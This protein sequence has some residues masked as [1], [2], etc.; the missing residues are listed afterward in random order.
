MIRAWVQVVILNAFFLPSVFAE[1][2]NLD[3]AIERALNTDPR[4]SE[5]E[6]LVDVARATLAE[7]QGS[8]DL[9]ISVNSFIGLSPGLTGGLSVN[10]V[11]CESGKGCVNRTD[12]YTLE[13]GLSLWNYI[14]YRIIKPLY[15][16]GKI[17]HF[18]AAARANIGIKEGDVSVRQGA[19]VLQVKQA[20]YGHLAAADTYAFL[21]DM[22]SRVD[23]S[24]EAVEIW[25]EDG[26]GHVKNADL[27]ALQTAS[28]IAA[29]YISQA[30][31]LKKISLDGLKVLIGVDLEG[32]L[33]LAD[34][35]IRPVP[36]PEKTLEQLKQ[37][38][39][40]VRPEMRQL[41]FGLKARRSLVAANKALS[42][43]NIYTG[44]GGMISYSPNRDRL[45][46]PHIYDPFNDWGGTPVLGMQWEWQG[47]VSSAK[48]A[49][50]KAELAALIEK[51]SFARSGIPFQ[52]SES[53]HNVHAFHD[54]V[55][56]LA[57]SSR[58][59][60]RWMISTYTDFDAGLEQAEKIVTAFQGYVLAHSGYLQT[61]YEYNMHVA[62]LDNVTGVDR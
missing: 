52:V 54:A 30:E 32:E 19:T 44:F 24:I 11:D 3:Q 12:R 42:K 46:N 17:K 55:K 60:R 41:E 39:L 56:N 16:F 29:S 20:Y 31:A 9:K 26:E 13:E 27:F 10:D 4:I 8:D 38:A 37:Q 58:A 21:L 18:S 40:L 5:L 61:V 22:K 7:A 43:P 34:T 23:A 48:V 14:D 49:K 59:A 51:S 36:L 28:G 35:R 50:S 57:K 6:K 15:T 45:D 1:P 33:E 62:K 53:Y 2:L 25:L 47:G